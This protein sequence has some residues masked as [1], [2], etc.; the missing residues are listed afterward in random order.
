MQSK[1]HAERVLADHAINGVTQA[2]LANSVEPGVSSNRLHL[3]DRN[4]RYFSIDGKMGWSC[5]EQWATLTMR[6]IPHSDDGTT[7]G[8]WIAITCE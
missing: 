3:L 2:R 4:E 8:D 7:F 6:E 1:A 5:G